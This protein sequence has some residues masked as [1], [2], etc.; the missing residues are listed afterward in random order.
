MRA[1]TRLRNRRPSPPPGP[2]APATLALA[3]ATA[4]AFATCSEAFVEL[5]ALPVSDHLYHYCYNTYSNYFLINISF[6]RMAKYTQIWLLKYLTNMF[7]LIQKLIEPNVPHATQW[8][9]IGKF[10]LIIRHKFQ[11]VKK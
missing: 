4:R 2:A 3:A 11:K 5:E 7:Q 10:S 1:A 9:Q 8:F 6:S